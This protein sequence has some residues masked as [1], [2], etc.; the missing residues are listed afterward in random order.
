[1][2]KVRVFVG[3]V[4]RRI[5]RRLAGGTATFHSEVSMRVL[6]HDGRVEDLGVVGRKCVTTAFCEMLVDALQG[7]SGVD[8]SQFIYHD[9]GTGNTAEAA[10]DTALATPCGEARSLGNQ[11]EGTSAVVYKTVATHSFSGAFTIREHGVFNAAASGTLLD[12]T[13]ISTPVDVIATDR[14]EST[15]Q[16]TVIAGG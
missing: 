5:R 16:L 14:I 15:Y 9:Y 3:D 6:R 8:I 7:V 12:R 4:V 13:V 11:G 2:D 1:M 10:G